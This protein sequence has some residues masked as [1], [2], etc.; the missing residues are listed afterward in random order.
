[1]S[2]L[3]IFRITLSENLL[4]ITYRK[5]YP[6]RKKSRS[7]IIEVLSAGNIAKNFKNVVFGDVLIMYNLK[8][9]F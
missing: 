1:M 8:F 4:S 5:F 6:I 9:L 7:L 2:T 3:M